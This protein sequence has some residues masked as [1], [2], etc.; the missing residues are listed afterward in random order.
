L[1]RKRSIP[2]VFILS[3]DPQFQFRVRDIRSSL[4]GGG[5]LDRLHGVDRGE[6]SV[7]PLGLGVDGLSDRG[8]EVEDDAEP[9]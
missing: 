8:T 7:D 4:H 2:L 9:L 1:T 3:N 5:A 6:E